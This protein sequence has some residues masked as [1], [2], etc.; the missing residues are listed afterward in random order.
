MTVDRNLEQDFIRV[1]EQ[2]AIAA[3]RTMGLGDRK[4]FKH[5]IEMG[6]TE[7]LVACDIA[8]N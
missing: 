2:A 3:A 6:L 8:H 1:T 5:F 7:P 4:K